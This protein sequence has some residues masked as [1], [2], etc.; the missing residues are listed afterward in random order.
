MTTQPSWRIAYVWLA[1][2]AN[3]RAFS[4]PPGSLPHAELPCAVDMRARIN[5]AE[6][7][8]YRG[9]DSCSRKAHGSSSCTEVDAADAVFAKVAAD[10]QRVAALGAYALLMRGRIAEQIR[11]D[12]A[13]AM[14][15]YAQAFAL[16]PLP[17]ALGT[18]ARDGNEPE[19]PTET[20]LYAAELCSAALS[21]SG[22]ADRA[23]NEDLI[24][25]S[26]S[27]ASLYWLVDSL[28]EQ[29]AALAADRAGGGASSTAPRLRRAL[30]RLVRALT[31]PALVDA[32]LERG[33]QIARLGL[34]KFT[35]RMNVRIWRNRLL[36]LENFPGGSSVSPDYRPAAPLPKPAEPDAFVHAL[37]IPKTAGTK[38]LG[39][40]ETCCAG[41]ATAWGEIVT[42]HHNVGAID[43]SRWM[44]G[45]AAGGGGRPG[46]HAAAHNAV[47]FLRDPFDR[48]ESAFHHLSATAADRRAGN[49]FVDIEVGVW[50]EYATPSEFAEAAARAE[51]A[52]SDG[53]R[54]GEHH[55]LEA[56]ALALIRFEEHFTPQA[57]YLLA[58][59]HPG[60]VACAAAA[61]RRGFGAVSS[62]GATRSILPWIAPRLHRPGFDRSNATAGDT[63]DLGDSC[64]LDPS[65]AF[66]GDVAHFEAHVKALF[67]ALFGRKGED[68]RFADV[69]RRISALEISGGGDNLGYIDNF[70]G[71]AS[72]AAVPGLVANK[73]A[74]ARHQLSA[75]AREFI[76]RQF[77]ADFVLGSF[78]P[79]DA[80]YADRQRLQG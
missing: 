44:G 40:L 61:A 15:L 12:A 63:A 19:E 35:M 30:A 27:F 5:D 13:A 7:L 21:V 74:Y 62:R 65:V 11:G 32:A 70:K 58:G 34:H 56:R 26:V 1:C 53:A 29:H 16:A 3:T 41:R 49:Q 75:T 37:H 10:A 42:W 14:P 22:A 36:E 79:S 60:A 69:E 9:A 78:D 38:L 71:R 48:F 46:G 18:T 2:L 8:M 72:A 64:A 28:F 25:D 51:A 31:R 23:P 39:L 67:V 52:E 6:A 33:D 45:A 76:R 17:S 59:G 50:E 55:A 66:L 47:A 43:T 80:S 57:A 77:A 20:G 4:S 54:G 68:P 24:G 73:G